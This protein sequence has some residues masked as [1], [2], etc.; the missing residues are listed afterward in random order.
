MKEMQVDQKFTHVAS[1]EETSLIEAY[2]S[3]LEIAIERRYVFESVESIGS[4]PVL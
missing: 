2:H 1:P 4:V 3:I